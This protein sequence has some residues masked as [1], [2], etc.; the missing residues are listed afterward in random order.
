MSYLNAAVNHIK[1]SDS[2]HIVEFLHKGQKLS[3]MS[4]ELSEEVT[5]GISVKLLVKPM[6]IAI[7]K[8]ITGS[9]SYSNQ[10]KS[11]IVSI[12]SGELLSSIKLN[13]LDTILESVITTKSSRSMNLQI[14]DEVVAFIKASDLSISEIVDA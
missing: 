6:H 7:G 13:Y 11:T 1:S 3:M 5:Q 9:L 2:L 4:L 8:S 12:E 14:G 10:L